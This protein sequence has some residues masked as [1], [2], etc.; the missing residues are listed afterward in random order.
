VGSDETD[1]KIDKMQRMEK[2]EGIVQ[3]RNIWPTSW[4][5]CVTVDWYGG[6]VAEKS[7]ALREGVGL[8]RR[9]GQ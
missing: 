9:Y 3:S 4:L 5:K 2:T 7:L 8:R 1:V 6:Y